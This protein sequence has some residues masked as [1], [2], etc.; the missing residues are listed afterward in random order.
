[1]LTYVDVDNFKRVYKSVER[2]IM[3]GK[4]ANSREAI[5]EYIK[6]L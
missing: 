2:N 3:E 6:C 5:V 1:M 4:L